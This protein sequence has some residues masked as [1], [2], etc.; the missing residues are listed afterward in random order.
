MTMNKKRIPSKK[1]SGVPTPVPIVAI[2]ASAGGLAAFDAFFSAMPAALDTGMAFVLIQHLAP[3]H[4]SLLCELIQKH[5]SMPVTEV[6][7]GTIIQTN[8]VYV[9][10]PN[11]DMTLVNGSL[12]LSEPSSPRGQR[13]PIDMFFLSLAAA[14]HELAIGVILSGTG[15]DGTLGAIAIKDEGGM[16]MS[17]NTES[18]EYDGMPRSVI[19]A[20]VVDYVLPP[21][22]MPAAL[23]D[24]VTHAPPPSA[25]PDDTMKKIFTLLLAHT[26]HDFSLYKPNTISRRVA[27]RMAVHK[28]SDPEEYLRYLQQTPAELDLLFKDL[29]IGVTSFFRDK[30]A[31]AVL[32]SQ[33]IPSLFE[34]KTPGSAI[35]VWVPACSTG[36][37]AY[38]IAILL[39]ERM[40]A[41]KQHF[42]LQVFA[43]DIDSKA[44]A[45]GRSALYPETVAADL[46]P[47]RLARFFVPSADGSYRVH[48]TIRDLLIFSEHDLIKDPPFSKLNL[49]SCRNLLIYLEP[50]LQK[51]IL[52]LFHFALNSCGIL[53]LGSSET[54]GE[55]ADVFT[56]IDPQAKLYQRKEDLLG[57]ARP[58]RMKYPSLRPDSPATFQN[59]GRN[60]DKPRISLRELTEKA[61]LEHYA[62]VGALVNEHGDLLYL[63]GYAGQ[64]LEP[65]QGE[66]RL[67][68]LLKM[69]HGVLQKEIT[70][71]LQKAVKQND[72]I[73]RKGLTVKMKETLS[74]IDLTVKP[75]GIDSSSCT[76]TTLFLVIL[77]RAQDINHPC[78]RIPALANSKEFAENESTSPF[79]EELKRELKLKEEYLQ[80]ANE[81]RE[82]S[83]DEMQA[84]NEE[85]Q[86]TNEEMETSKEELQSVNEELYTVNAELQAKV[87]DLTWVNNDMNN[88]LAGTGVGTVFV[89]H[90]LRIRRFTPAATQVINLIQ[91]DIGRPVEHI[92]SNL[93]GYNSLVED[94]QSVLETLIPL[95]VEVQSKL[96]E[97]FLLHISPYR[98]L[99]N[100]IEGGVISFFNISQMKRTQSALRETESKYRI[101]FETMPQGVIFLN[102]KGQILD[103]NSAAERILGLTVDKMK[104][105]DPF[106]PLGKTL[107]KDGTDFPREEQPAITALTTGQKVH[108]VVMGLRPPL[109][110]NLIWIRVNAI[111]QFWP[112][113]NKPYQVYMTIDDITSDIVKP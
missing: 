33:A 105:R 72:K 83:N 49:I 94:L 47:E 17:Q 3:D 25:R 71:A 80:R 40:D 62:A 2:G 29:L 6:E 82:T 7:D 110:K 109:K 19:A 95:E 69:A 50:D 9:I 108:E 99:E 11:R 1:P 66:Q 41:L 4:K 56:T 90:Q 111:P 79:I 84:V 87:T 75:V 60:F 52:R 77:E 28:L 55:Y 68:S 42:K 10:P 106:N 98:T 73:V 54:V 14:Q 89:D 5:T 70:R 107:R 48:K 27:K 35:R 93:V 37:E 85:L 8:H 67:N 32:E 64:Y 65:A 43:T 58:T 97:W 63:E 91:S 15:N 57:S 30:E 16:V 45:R 21:A 113:E 22:E 59:S 86:S 100:V 96:G 102:D 46:T 23:I 112:G 88:L 103:A 76:E 12:Q 61:L 18:A 81:A 44:I 38:S 34:G 24:F 92:A 53:F 78:Q 26:G 31:F 36:E 51:R 74:V 20:G 101:L 13:L 104:K 39:Q